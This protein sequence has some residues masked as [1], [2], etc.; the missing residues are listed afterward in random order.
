MEDNEELRFEIIED[1]D[2]IKISPIKI[3]FS[4][5]ELTWDKNWIEAFVEIKALPFQ[6]KYKAQL[7]T[8]DFEKFKQELHRI[9]NDLSGV[10]EFTC[11]EEF[12]KIKIKGDGIGHFNAECIAQDTTSFPRSRLLFE[13]HFDQTQIRGM[14]KQLDQ[15]TK[16]FPIVGD[17]LGL[18]N[19]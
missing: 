4:D 15:I 8:I 10:T 18:K 7:M 3:M 19:I 5:S 14:I 16:L 12:I 11:L 2:F 13:L 9:Y 6:G 17:D 1:V